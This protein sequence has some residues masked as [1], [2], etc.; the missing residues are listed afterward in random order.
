MIS[1]LL[2]LLRHLGLVTGAS[3]LAAVFALASATVDIGTA[4]PQAI[5]SGMRMTF[6]V[7]LGL[8]VVACLIA[9][10][11]QAGAR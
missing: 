7:A 6:L 4:Q 1:G 10:R 3:A 5:A 8:I 2:N 9:W 11:R